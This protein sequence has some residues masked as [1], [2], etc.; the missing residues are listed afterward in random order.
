MSKLD[1]PYERGT[2]TI[3]DWSKH[4]FRDRYSPERISLT[5]FLPEHVCMKH[6]ERARVTPLYITFTHPFRKMHE[7]PPAAAAVVRHAACLRRPAAAWRSAT[8]ACGAALG[9][10]PASTASSRSAQS[11]YSLLLHP[12]VRRVE[13]PLLCLVAGAP[14]G[15][16]KRPRRNAHLL[17]ASSAHA[18]DY[19][20]SVHGSVHLDELP[21]VTREAHEPSPGSALVEEPCLPPARAQAVDM[22]LRLHT[23]AQPGGW[24]D[25]TSRNEPGQEA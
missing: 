17:G 11:L 8:A 24:H 6:N 2:V 18:S 7:R 20:G 15:D 14:H 3:S 12:R 21:D 5:V 25:S 13:R 9:R 22:A 16:R 1:W 4:L 23:H 19:R 10:R